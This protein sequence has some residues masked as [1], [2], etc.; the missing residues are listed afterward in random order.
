MSITTSSMSVTS[1]VPNPIAQ[2]VNQKDLITGVDLRKQAAPAVLPA[3]PGPREGM[4]Q[5]KLSAH[6]PDGT[7]TAPTADTEGVGA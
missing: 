2:R 1:Q 5:T 6:T 3:N 4:S 7:A